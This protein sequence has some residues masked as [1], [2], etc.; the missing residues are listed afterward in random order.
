MCVYNNQERWHS[1][2]HHLCVRGGHHWNMCDTGAHSTLGCAPVFGN[3]VSS[4]ISHDRRDAMSI[5]HCHKGNGIAKWTNCHS[6]Y[7]S[8]GAP[9]KGIYCHS[10]RWPFWTMISALRGEGD[11]HLPTGNP[12]LVGALHVTSRQSLV[13]SQTKS[14]INSWRISIRRS[15]F[16]SCMQP[17]QSSTNSLGRTIREW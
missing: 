13:T 8:F 15:H 14:C 1:A 2:W 16:M 7:S 4:F 17:Q 5:T 3:G 9:C 11:S 10:G 6:N 12:H